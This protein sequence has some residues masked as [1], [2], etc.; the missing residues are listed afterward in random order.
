MRTG[1]PM[2]QVTDAALGAVKCCA[3]APGGARLVA[4]CVDGSASAW[5]V[6]QCSCGVD[7]YPIVTSKRIRSYICTNSTN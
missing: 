2:W 6:A 3:F 4:Y 1:E 5:D 7:V